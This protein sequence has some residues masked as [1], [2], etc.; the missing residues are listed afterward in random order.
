V[1]SAILGEY[2]SRNL[3]FRFFPEGYD[4]ET[5]RGTNHGGR[6]AGRDRLET[7]LRAVIGS[8]LR[9]M[10][11]LPGGSKKGVY[12]LFL[13]NSSTAIAYVWAENENFWPPARIAETETD[14][15]SH[16]SG[17]E[18]FLA[19][20][21]RLR[22]L[23][24]R[25]PEL[26]LTDQTQ[27][28]YPA[29]I[30]VVEDVPGDNLETLL[31][32]SP[33]RAEVTLG[34]LAGA[35]GQMAEDTAQCIG[36]VAVIGDGGT[37]ETRSCEQVVL[38]RALVDLDEA[39]GRDER[40]AHARQDLEEALRSLAAAVRGRS[41]YGLIHGELGPDHVLVDQH[42]D[43]VLIDIE[44]LMFFDV[45]WEHAFLRIRFGEHYA[46]LDTPGLDEHRLRFYELA[47]RLSLVAGPLRILDGDFPDRAEMRDIAEH[48]LQRALELLA[49]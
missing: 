18:L 3:H 15:F 35:L 41:R 1:N 27:R 10:S 13:S 47:M 14:P 23:G 48:N 17:I 37:A 2:L 46:W 6:F 44:G 42:Q 19:A 9:G 34:R 33:V 11:R 43:P 39:A 16:A 26:R 7:A 24:I 29:D 4:I 8:D 22:A 40:I 31:Q 38:H 32:Q 20:H 21:R 12:R 45:E 30:A 5:T 28:H 36:K 49:R 25:T